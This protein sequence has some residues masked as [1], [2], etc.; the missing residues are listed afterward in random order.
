MGIKKPTK[1]HLTYEWT[2]YTACGRYLGLGT[3]RPK[4]HCHDR[5][6][7]TCKNCIKKFDEFDAVNE[8]QAQGVK[9]NQKNI[10][11]KIKE[12][13]AGNPN[14]IR[15]LNLNAKAV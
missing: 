4:E 5:K 12:I 8:L 2:P 1:M 9:L 6:K 14:R 11:I 13:K 7:T 10:R 15:G 3:Q